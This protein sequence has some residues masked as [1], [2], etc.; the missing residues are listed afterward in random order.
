LLSRWDRRFWIAGLGGIFRGFLI[1]AKATLEGRD[2]Y[3]N[4]TAITS[5][6][7]RNWK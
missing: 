4:T 6:G 5:V 2:I 3:N 7:Q 1:R